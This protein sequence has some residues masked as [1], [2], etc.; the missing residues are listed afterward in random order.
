VFELDDWHSGVKDSLNFGAARDEVLQNVCQ[1]LHVS[2]N[3]G[4]TIATGCIF[5]VKD[6]P[7]IASFDFLEKTLIVIIF[8]QFCISCCF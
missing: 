4:S 8:V 7:T 6:Q 3:Q 2:L 1:N 5:V